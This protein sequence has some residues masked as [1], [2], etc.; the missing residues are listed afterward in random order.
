MKFLLKPLKK[1][2][3]LS[4]KKKDKTKK[5]NLGGPGKRTPRKQNPET[6]LWKENARRKKEE[7]IF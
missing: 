1:E 4:M 2:V 5:V 7:V 3:K 6:V